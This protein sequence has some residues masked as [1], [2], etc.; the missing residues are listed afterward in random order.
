[1]HK[2][3]LSL[4]LLLAASPV[5]A[6]S[7]E[8][9]TVP[10]AVS[11][12]DINGS[13][14][15]IRNSDRT[16]LK[17]GAETDIKNVLELWYLRREVWA[18]DGV[19]WIGVRNGPASPQLSKYIV[20]PWPQ[21]PAIPVTAGLRMPVGPQDVT[22]TGVNLK[23]GDNIQTAVAANAENTIFC[24]AAGTYPQQSVT[25]K[26]GQQFIGAK[27]ATLDGQSNTQYAFGGK[28]PY[29]VIRN[30]IIK[31]YTAPTQYAMV[32]IWGPYTVI[33]QNEVSGATQ[34]AGVWAGH[35]ALVIGN[36]IHDNAE[37]GYKVVYDARGSQ[38]AVG[39]LFDGNDIFNNNPTRGFWDS[40]EQG[41]GKTWNTQHA[42]F[43]YNYSHDNGGPGFWTDYDNIWTSY[44]YNKA[45]YNTNGIEHEISYNASIIGND[46]VGNGG[47]DWASNCPSAYFS[48][49]GVAI[50]NSGSGTGP[51]KGTIE[52]AYNNIVPGKH[53]R[54][55][56]YREQNRGQG[57]YGPWLVRSVNAH[58]NT[59]DVTSG[60]ADTQVGAAQDWGDTALFTQGGV[61]FDY[62]SY[63]GFGTNRWF[64]WNN[65]GYLVWA[66]W[67]S[68]GQDRNS[69]YK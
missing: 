40:G 10:V 58:H 48:C 51:Y 60:M 37:E 65:N 14:W 13:V 28:A 42:S 27:G 7:T 9:T 36:Y 46:L 6:E 59:I 34:G 38:P 4:W 63:V 50:E 16:V 21:R 33:Q 43:W 57:K 2:L 35:H 68:V 62:N 30:L 31:N 15:T 11:I 41:G 18:F 25:P 66:Q 55:V 44:W 12:T 17:D 45:Y 39:V 49:A 24:L 1:M 53:G 69:T 56:A 20:L 5:L 29:V 54:A 23:P 47:R 32:S 26:A 64:T 3:L 67:Q 8:A 61:T 22:C 19:Q 52:I